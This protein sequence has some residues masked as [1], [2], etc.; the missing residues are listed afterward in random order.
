M[1]DSPVVHIEQLSRRF[2]NTHA[3]TEV[4]LRVRPGFVYGLVGADGAWENDPDQT[5]AGTA[6][7]SARHGEGIRLG[8]RAE[9]CGSTATDRL[10]IR[11]S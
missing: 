5:F 8:T 3:L 10:S 11:E 2:G 9:S 6:A 4:S 1:N 7:S